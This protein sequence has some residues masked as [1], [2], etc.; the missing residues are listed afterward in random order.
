MLEATTATTTTSRPCRRVEALHQWLQ[1]DNHAY[2]DMTLC[3]AVTCICAVAPLSCRLLEHGAKDSSELQMLVA[4]MSDE[5]L[6][7]V[8]AQGA[9]G[10]CASMGS[11]LSSSLQS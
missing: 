2:S 4:P 8:K 6:L 10:S 11:S 5:E 1:H 7:Q 3:A 9:W